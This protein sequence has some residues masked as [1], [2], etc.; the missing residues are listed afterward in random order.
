MPNPNPGQENEVLENLG[1]GR[2]SSFSSFFKAW[3]SS[4]PAE[5]KLPLEFF[6]G[7]FG[8]HPISAS[9]RGAEKYPGAP[10]PDSCCSGSGIRWKEDVLNQPKFQ[11][12]LPGQ[13]R[14]LRKGKGGW[15]GSRDLDLPR[16]EG[17]EGKG[18]LQVQSVHGKLPKHHWE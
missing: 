9:G 18:K 11:L 12:G 7:S 14:F 4:V 6:L 1:V 17:E 15:N 13:E 10:S 2:V 16:G 3:I 8:S 5:P